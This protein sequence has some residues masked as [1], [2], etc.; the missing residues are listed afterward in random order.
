MTTSNFKFGKKD[1]LHFFPAVL[2]V[3]Y[4]VFIFI[5]DAN[6]NGFDTKQNG[7]LMESWAMGS[8]GS[9]AEA[10]NA[11]QQ[12]LYLAFSL[13]LYFTYKKKIKN[14]FSNTYKLELNWIRNFLYIYSF[15]FLYGILQQF[16]ILSIVELSWIQKWWYQFFSALAVI[17][18]GIK[19]YFTDTTSLEGLDFQLLG[20]LQKSRGIKEGSVWHSKHENKGLEN[21]KERLSQFMEAQR[22]YLNPD[23][24]LKEMAQELRMSRGQL[25]EVINIGFGKNFNDF[26]NTYRI[27]LVKDMLKAGRHKKLSLLGI[28][29]ECGFNSKAT[30]NRVFKKFTNSSPTEFL[31]NSF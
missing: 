15:L 24:N 27:N 31:N 13:Q 1:W 8:V 29:Y 16:V 2:Y 18:I 9:F 30:F 10:F 23:L 6:Q 22:P 17:Y 4:R 3:L 25:S 28:A 11:I 12:I 26:I 7:I 20:I 14:Y 5:Y 19:G 21:Q